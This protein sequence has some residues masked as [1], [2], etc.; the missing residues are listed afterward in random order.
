VVCS[1][2]NLKAVYSDTKFDHVAKDHATTT[3][4]LWRLVLK[5]VERRYDNQKHSGA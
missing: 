1:S 4:R 2:A 5:T 3:K